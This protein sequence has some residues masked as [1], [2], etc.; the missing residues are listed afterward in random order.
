M[1]GETNQWAPLVYDNLAPVEIPKDP[2]YHFMN[3]MTNQA[4]AW[5]RF[6]KALTPDRPFF[7]YFAPGATHAPAPRA[8][9]VDREVQGQVRQGLGRHAGGS[10][11]PAR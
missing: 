2:N 1:G 4:I 11:W 5:M 6:Q 8:E 7:M 10:C 3:D 9:G